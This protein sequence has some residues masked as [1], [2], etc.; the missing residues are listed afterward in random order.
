MVIPG[1]LE[2]AARPFLLAATKGWTGNAPRS[3]TKIIRQVK[4][5]L[6]ELRGAT[7]TVVVFCDCW[8]STAFQ[9]EHAEST[10]SVRQHRHPTQRAVRPRCGHGRKR[11]LTS[12]GGRPRDEYDSESGGRILHGKPGLN[13][14]V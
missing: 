2:D 5:R 13:A 10:P 3:F 12:A 4:A 7:H 6:I 8:D 9:E 14:G 1:Y 11:S